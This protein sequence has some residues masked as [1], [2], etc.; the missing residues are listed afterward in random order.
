MTAD[1]G[2][3]LAHYRQH[4]PRCHGVA[5]HCKCGG[6]WVSSLE[7][8]IEELTR[9]GLGNENTG[10][11]AVVKFSQRPCPECGGPATETRPA[12]APEPERS[13]P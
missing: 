12:W 13:A 7:T 2:V 10:I 5:F 3:P 9:R 11:R 6:Y 8:V 4:A 1:P